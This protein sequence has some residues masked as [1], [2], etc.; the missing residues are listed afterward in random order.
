MIKFHPQTGEQISKIQYESYLA[1]CDPKKVERTRRKNVKIS[2]VELEQERLEEEE[3]LEKLR[4]RKE[5]FQKKLYFT[6]KGI[7]TREQISD[8]EYI[9]LMARRRINQDTGD[10]FKSNYEY[11]VYRITHTINPETGKFY[12]SLNERR[13]QLATVRKNLP[14]NL[15]YRQELRK[16]M[17]ERGISTYGL[18]R[19][20]NLTHQTISNYINGVSAPSIRIRKRIERVLNLESII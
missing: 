17:N 13:L 18:A 20:V 5:K 11:S 2:E 16:R 6:E 12:K 8:S 15:E 9:Q 19:E 4:K 10:F 14:K 3:K 1:N 7:F